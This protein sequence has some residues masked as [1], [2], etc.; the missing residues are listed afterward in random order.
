MMKHWEIVVGTFEKIIISGSQ[1]NFST[2]VH[3]LMLYNFN[4]LKTR[5]IYVFL[6]SQN[7]IASADKR[8]RSELCVVTTLHSLLTNRQAKASADASSFYY[9]II[10][11]NMKRTEFYIYI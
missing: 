4:Q 11:M 1:E 2:L 7:F 3:H 8:F 9:K 10:K 6:V 5:A